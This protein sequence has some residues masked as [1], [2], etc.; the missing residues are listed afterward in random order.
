MKE[1]FTQIESFVPNAN[2][3]ATLEKAHAL[4]ALVL[5]TRPKLVVEVGTYAGRSAVP[6]AIALKHIGQGTLI[7]ID[8]YDAQA[9]AENENGPNSEWWLRLDHNKI[10]DEFNGY[11][12]R[13]GLQNVVK[14]IRQRS[15]HVEPPENIDIFH[16]DGSHA[17]QAM[18][19]VS[20]F[21]PK[22]VSG[23]FVILDDLHWS[24]NAVSA[25]AAW[26]EANGFRLLYSVVKPAAG[27]DLPC[28]D[29]GVFIHST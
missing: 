13:F 26:L 16:C 21:A 19:D 28:D 12:A 5:S 7:G 22:V 11:V 27:K 25:A 15:N 6:M 17:E 8:P 2:G 23:G 24:S 4:A 29:W 1:V 14:L 9:S 3:W 10:L 18:I 20:R